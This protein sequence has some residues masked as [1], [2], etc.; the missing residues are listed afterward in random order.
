MLNDNHL[1]L[2]HKH[3]R[4][5]RQEKIASHRC[6]G[7]KSCMPLS[8]DYN[9]PLHHPRRRVNAS[10]VHFFHNLTIHARPIHPIPPTLTCTL[11][12]RLT[13]RTAHTNHVLLGRPTVEKTASGKL[14]PFSRF[15]PLVTPHPAE[16]V[17]RS[18]SRHAHPY[19][20]TRSLC[21]SAWRRSSRHRG[22]LQASPPPTPRHRRS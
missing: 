9:Q 16:P 21:H 7:I 5:S 18:S 8:C 14:P 22:A 6:M 10:H 4:C 15:V 12:C 13:H 17:R 3:A 2:Q 11:T 20:H 1:L 19:E